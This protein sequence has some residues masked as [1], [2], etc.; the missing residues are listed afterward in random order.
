M[1]KTESAILPL[2]SGHPA[3][4]LRTPQDEALAYALRSSG[5]VLVGDR[6]PRLLREYFGDCLDQARDPD[7][8]LLA[9]LLE[10]F[11]LLKNETREALD[12]LSLAHLL[13]SLWQQAGEDFALLRG[14]DRET[15]L[16]RAAKER[17]TI[18]R[19]RD[20]APHLPALRTNHADDPPAL[21]LL[22]LLALQIERCTA[23]KSSSVPVET[24]EL[25]WR[26]LCLCLGLPPEDPD[27]AAR[28]LPPGDPEQ[29]LEKGIRAVR[30]RV[31]EA[32]R[33]WQTIC[34]NP[35]PIV[36]HSLSDT[37]QSIGRFFPLYEPRCFA[38]RLPCDIDYPLAHPADESLAGIDYL[39]DWLTRLRAETT[40]LRRF[41]ARA[42]R[43]L[44]RLLGPDP[45]D[46]PTNLCAPAVANALARVLLQR[47]PRPLPSTP[48]GRTA[49]PTHPHPPAPP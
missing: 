23:Q 11:F 37:L 45:S 14:A 2:R 8:V 36:T 32:K 12:D 5:R 22:H 29:R 42:L 6:L 28:L 25:L 24:A 39:L 38:A 27:R 4:T 18:D 17:P 3:E 10:L 43:P 1:S 41:P 49:L 34:T 44:Y 40:F 15:L 31:R 47:D 21:R 19:L 48:A 16:S 30:Q 33:L 26:S 20:S 13:H 7:G 46:L 35:P 9:E